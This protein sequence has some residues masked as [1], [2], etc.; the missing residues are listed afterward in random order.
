VTFNDVPGNWGVHAQTTAV[1]HGDRNSSTNQMGLL[2]QGIITTTN[3]GT[4]AL[5]WAQ[6]ASIASNTRVA[7][8]SFMRVTRLA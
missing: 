3:A 1:S 4:V 8:G 2:E 6:D 5:Q 7:A